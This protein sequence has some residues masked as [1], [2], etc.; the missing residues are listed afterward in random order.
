GLMVLQNSVSFGLLRGMNPVR[1]LHAT[2]STN[3][4]GFMGKISNLC[5][6]L[7]QT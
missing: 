2:L 3:T 5:G 6:M 1:Y 7:I 4:E